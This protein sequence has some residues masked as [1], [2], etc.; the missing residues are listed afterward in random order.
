MPMVLTLVGW[1]LLTKSLMRLC[2]PKLGLKVMAQVALVVLAGFS[3]MAS[4]GVAHPG[5]RA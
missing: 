2:A 3:A 4:T 5:G 1:G